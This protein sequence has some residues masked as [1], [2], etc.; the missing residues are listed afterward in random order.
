MART[1]T[2]AGTDAERE[3]SKRVGALGE[4]RPFL[5][6]YKWMAVLAGLALV[7]TAGVSLTLPLAVRRVIDSFG[8]DSVAILDQYFGAALGLAALLAVGT[9][10]RYALVTRLGERVVADIR[11]AVFDR[12]ISMSPAFSNAS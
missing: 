3:K 5:V 7:L 10:L 2:P 9:G 4:L 6:P 1:P 11:K 8:S 12:I